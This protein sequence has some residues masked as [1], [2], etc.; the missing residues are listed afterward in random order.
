MDIFRFGGLRRLE[1]VLGIHIILAESFL[2]TPQISGFF[3]F[4]PINGQ[5]GKS[6]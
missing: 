1:S 6:E 3:P 2:W 4:L 5:K